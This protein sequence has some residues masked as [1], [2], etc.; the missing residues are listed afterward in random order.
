MVRGAD[1]LFGRGRPGLSLVV[2]VHDMVDQARRTLHSLSAAYQRGVSEREY[3]VIVVEN[4]SEH[5]LGEQQATQFG[6]NFRYFLRDESRPTPVFAVNFGAA[7]ARGAT[8]G[9]MIDGARML[10]PGAVR[11]ILMARR[12]DDNAVVAIPGYHL[13][14]QLQ[15]EALLRGYDQRAE[16]R[17]L[18]SIGWPQDGYRLFEIAVFSGTSRPGFFRFPG[19]SNCLCMPREVWEAVGGC[20]ERFD[21]P[22]GGQVNLD[23]Y[24]RVVEREDTL[25]VSLLGEGCFHQF[26]GGVTTGTRAEA[27]RALVDAQVEQYRKLRGKKFRNPR[28][29]SITLGL[30]PD[31]ALKFVDQSVRRALDEL[32][33]LDELGNSSTAPEPPAA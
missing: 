18:E 16:S 11:G 25:L 24:K 31:A 13:G 1:R 9:I 29:R 2:I 27:R 7:Q 17:L 5:M 28:V 3:E 8:I 20:D 6:A 22:G 32:D 30:V 12:M 26:H 4:S 23:L 21:L 14:E 15:Q 19:E 10:T 33:E